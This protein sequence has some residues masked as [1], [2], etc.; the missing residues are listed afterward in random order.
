M[1]KL[2]QVLDHLKMVAVDDNLESDRYWG[3]SF[4][5]KTDGSYSA[6]V[7]SSCLAI[8]VNDIGFVPEDRFF[9]YLDNKWYP[10][11]RYPLSNG[12]ILDK[13][14]DQNLDNY[15]RLTLPVTNLVNF[16]SQMENANKQQS[17]VVISR[18]IIDEGELICK[19]EKKLNGDCVFTHPRVNKP[20]IVEREKTKIPLKDIRDG[21][22]YCCSVNGEA[23]D[24]FYISANKVFGK[25]KIGIVHSPTG[26]FDMKV[27]DVNR[28]DDIEQKYVLG[29][30][31]VKNESHGFSHIDCMR[32]WMVC[33]VFVMSGGKNID[34]FIHKTDPLADIFISN[35]ET[36]GEHVISAK[37]AVLDPY[38]GP[39][40]R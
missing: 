21:E 11:T 9:G 39:Q 2:D 35:Q 40:R 19:L 3:V 15:T 10:E 5:E 12:Y 8:E 30:P 16:L 25:V 34:I 26:F 29:V 28:L 7:A 13:L 36:P 6:I 1:R 23:D 24:V 20:F 32:L 31:D 38:A 33:K 27:E 37:I 14:Y 17:R 22:Y 4:D 18:G